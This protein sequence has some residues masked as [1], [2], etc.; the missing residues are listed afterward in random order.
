M[1]AKTDWKKAKNIHFSKRRA[2]DAK[3]RRRGHIPLERD[4]RALRGEGKGEE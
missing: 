4:G 1:C 2:A 3:G